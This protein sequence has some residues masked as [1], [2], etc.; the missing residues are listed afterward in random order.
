MSQIETT[1]LKGHITSGL[2]VPDT[3]VDFMATFNTDE[4]CLEYIKMV[5]YPNGWICS[6]C[7]GKKYGLVAT[8]HL[9]RCTQCNYEDSLVAGTLMRYT[10]KPL[11]HW[12][13]VLY[14]VATQKTGLSAMEVYRQLKLG[15]YGTAWTWLQKIRMAMVSPDRTILSGKVEVDETYIQTGNAGKGRRMA[16]RKALIICAVEIKPDDEGG[17]IISGRIRLRHIPN[18]SAENIHP[19]IKDH[20]ERGSNVYTDGWTGYQGISKYGYRHI[21]DVIGDPKEA[22][23]KFPRVHRVFANLHAWLL[24]THRYISAKHLQNYLNEYTFRFNRRH[25]TKVSFNSLL[26]IAVLSEP[27]TYKGFTTPERPI[28]RNPEG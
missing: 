17:K 18:A 22:S 8:R 23:N 20:I 24:G 27:R 11:R 14:M 1:T 21:I 3:I 4:K 9:L 26:K 25:F 16:G 6:H 19:F 10:K 15:H 28:Y 2:I 13:W 12:F 7:G 5:K